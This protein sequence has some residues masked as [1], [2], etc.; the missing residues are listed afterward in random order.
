MGRGKSL[1]FGY[2][3]FGM[4]ENLVVSYRPE[5][6]DFGVYPKWPM[7]GEE[8]IHPEDR[9]AAGK[10]APSQ[11]V[12]RRHKWDGEYYWLEYGEQSY[13]VKPSMWLP[14]PAVDLRV[15]EQV[16]VLQSKGDHD[17]GIFH[18]ADIFFNL[19]LREVEF[20]LRRGEMR[21]ASPFQRQ[22]LRP[23]HVKH[24]LRERT[25]EFKPPRDLTP[26]SVELL[27]VGEV[28]SK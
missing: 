10:L 8:W 19:Q 4:E 21:L 7:P 23:L 27:N 13:R 6:P 5:L 1:A 9:Q 3:D 16:E 24:R 28:T 20:F 25:F 14:V 11:R 17:P 22:A 26:E 18:V 15:G 12:F 2:R